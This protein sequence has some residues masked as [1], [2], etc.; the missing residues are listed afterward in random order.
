MG[1]VII[2]LVIGGCMAAAGLVMRRHLAKERDKINSEAAAASR[3]QGQT[4]GPGQGG[5][6]DRLDSKDRVAGADMI[7]WRP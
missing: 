7:R 2:S 3:A 1:E 4:K 5:R 6:I